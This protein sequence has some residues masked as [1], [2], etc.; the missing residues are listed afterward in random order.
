[1][2]IDAPEGIGL[3]TMRLVSSLGFPDKEISIRKEG[4]KILL[5]DGFK[6][7]DSLS[8]RLIFEIRGFENPDTFEKSKPFDISILNK[9]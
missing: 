4:Q 2:T 6:S 8:D 9:D 3:G 1:M 7:S 5:E